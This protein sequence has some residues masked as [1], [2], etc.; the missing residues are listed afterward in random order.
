MQLDFESIKSELINIIRLKHLSLSTEKTYV[1]WVKRFIYFLN[2][3]NVM[4]TDS[5][6]IERFL[7]YLAIEK[8]VSKSTQS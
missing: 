7:T 2:K 1:G 8:K 3:N 5:Q 4:H 6:H